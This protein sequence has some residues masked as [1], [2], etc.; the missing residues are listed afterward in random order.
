MKDNI[1]AQRPSI[2]PPLVEL[3]VIIEINICN[4][5]LIL[6]SCLHLCFSIW[7]LFQDEKSLPYNI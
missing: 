4:N 1:K 3:K 6:K 7:S 2:K 5:I